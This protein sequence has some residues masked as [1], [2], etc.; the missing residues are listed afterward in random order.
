MSETK[1]DSPLFGLPLELREEIYKSVLSD[2]SQGLEILRTC[3]EIQH[4]AQKFLYQRRLIFPSQGALY[5]WLA[6]TPHELLAY[7]SSIAIHIQDIDLRPILGDLIASYQSATPLHLPTS[8]LYRAEVVALGRALK[9]MPKLRII[10]LRALLHQPSKLYRHYTTQVLRLLSTSCPCLLD[11]R[12]EGNF[13]HQGLEFLMTLSNRLES[14]SFDGFSLSSPGDTIKILASLGHLRNL[15]LV[16]EHAPSEP[17]I[18]LH[19]NL[20]AKVGPSTEQDLRAA[21]RPPYLFTAGGIPVLSPTSYFISEVLGS[22]HGHNALRSISLQLSYAPDFATLVSLGRF[23]KRSPITQLEL[24]WPDLQPD[25]L[26]LCLLGSDVKTVRVRTHYE[27]YAFDILR[28]IVESQQAGDLNNLRKVVLVR[29]KTFHEHVRSLRSDVKTTSLG[30]Y[31]V[32]LLQGC[33]TLAT[34]CPSA[35][36]DRKALLRV[37]RTTRPSCKLSGVCKISG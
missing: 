32:S 8:E 18:G 37:N 30:L 7:V 19:G 9:E 2:P 22:L 29:P 11:L 28:S 24:D 23:F 6:K 14:F 27:A 13:H 15:S 4:E 31:N 26:E 34:R 5:T 3:H 36:T 12:L 21:R 35:D 16:S 20:T 33:A 25:V 1:Q 17:D 10:T